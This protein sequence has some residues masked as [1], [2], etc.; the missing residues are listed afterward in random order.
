MAM[1][2]DRE[3]LAWAAGFFDGEGTAVLANTNSTRVNP[4]T[5]VRRD[6]PTPHLAVTQHYDPETVHR[7]HRAVLGLGKVSGPHSS[8][9]TAHHPRWAWTCRRPHETIAVIGLL[10]PFLSTPKREQ[11]TRMM[12]PYLADVP[13]RRGYSF[14]GASA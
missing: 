8:A 14:T 5:G 9:G 7:F 3:A 10:W 6:Y 12:K 11:I 4:T 1:V 2:L 13:S